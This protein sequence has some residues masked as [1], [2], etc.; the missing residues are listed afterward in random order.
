[1]QLEGIDFLDTFALVA[2]L[3]TLCLLLAV[4]SSHNWDLKQLDVNN[5]F[6]HGDLLEEVYMKP[7]PGLLFLIHNSFANYNDPFMGC[8]RLT[9]NGMLNYHI[10]YLIMVMCYLLLIMPYFKKHIL[11]TSLFFLCM[12]T[13]LYSLETMLRKSQTSPPC[14]IKTSK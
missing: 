5:A 6:L 9:G 1:M 4:A 2:K 3:T 11:I 7:P 10:F 14:Y 12:S 8:D 13:T